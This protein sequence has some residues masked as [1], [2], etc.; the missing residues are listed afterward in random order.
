MANNFNYLKLAEAATRSPRK[1]NSFPV[2]NELLAAAAPAKGEAMDI[3]LLNPQQLARYNKKLEIP[4]KRRFAAEKL[5]LFLAREYAAQK[6]DFGEGYDL[7]YEG[8]TRKPQRLPA[9]NGGVIEYNT[10]PLAVNIYKLA[11]EYSGS[12][13][14]SGATMK[15]IIEALQALENFYVG[16]V[17]RETGKQIFQKL[18]SIDSIESPADNPDISSTMFNISLYPVFTRMIESNYSTAQLNV[19]KKITKGPQLILYELL[20]RAPRYKAFT[21]NAEELYKLVFQREGKAHNPKREKEDFSEAVELLKQSG[22]IEDF[23]ELEG[24]MYFYFKEQ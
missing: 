19:I 16:W 24:N 12:K 7:V 11:Q 5:K 3:T 20:I 6:K 15:C 13:H 23:Q 4:A 18:I 1:Y 2:S 8:A 14:P 9:A 10:T 21:K 17:D 22:V